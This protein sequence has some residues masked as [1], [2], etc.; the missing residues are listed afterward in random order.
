MDDLFTMYR[1]QVT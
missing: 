1:L